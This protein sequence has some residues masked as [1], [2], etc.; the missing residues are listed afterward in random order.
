MRLGRLVSSLAEQQ[1]NE[2]NGES[3]EVNR[4]AGAAVP[5]IRCMFKS[6]KDDSVGSKMG[7]QKVTIPT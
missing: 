5:I 1:L 7:R 6:D 4:A 2:R 3:S